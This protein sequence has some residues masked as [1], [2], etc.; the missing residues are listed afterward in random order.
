MHMS[1]TRS[2]LSLVPLAFLALCVTGAS[3]QP[4]LQPMKIALKSRKAPENALRRRALSPIDVPL[5]DYFNRTDL[6]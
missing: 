3:L 6:Q 2:M 4:H 5:K 1:P